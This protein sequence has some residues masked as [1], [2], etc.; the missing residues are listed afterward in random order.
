MSSDAQFALWMI[1]L[2]AVGGF[3]LL[4]IANIDAKAEEILKAIEDLKPKEK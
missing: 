4:T 1:S 2:I 3:F